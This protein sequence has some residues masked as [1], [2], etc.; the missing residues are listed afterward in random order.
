MIVWGTRGNSLDLG[1]V[2]EDS[3]S[4]CGVR[5]P[6]HAYLAYR[7]FHLYWVFAFITERKYMILCQVCKRGSVVDAHQIEALHR[8]IKIPFMRR[9]GIF[10][11][12]AIVATI[13]IIGSLQ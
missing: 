3:C 13:G 7:W 2:K 4:T 10:V 6:F 5:R 9:Y 12:I 1:P 11:L 8:E